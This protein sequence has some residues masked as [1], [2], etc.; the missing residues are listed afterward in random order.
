[1]RKSVFHS[2]K[3]YVP[4]ELYYLGW[5]PKGKACILLLVFK[6][7]VNFARNVPLK[8]ASTK[9]VGTCHN[10]LISNDWAIFII[11]DRYAKS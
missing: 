3:Q 8:L 1:M 5:N 9:Q 11:I 6:A 10:Q 2:T 7:N 4:F